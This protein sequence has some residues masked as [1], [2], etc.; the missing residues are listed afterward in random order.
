MRFV[1]HLLMMI[2]VALGIGF[3]LSHYALTDGK[4]FGAAQVGPWSAWPD[5][6]SAAP[7][8]Y[9]RG[10]LAREATL[11]L[12][13]SEGLRFTAAV[14]SEGLPLT[15]DCAYRMDGK[16]PLATFWTLVA[17]DSD[18]INIAAPDADPA[19]RSNA[20]ARANEGSLAINIGKRL[21]PGDWLEITG[22]GPFTLA[23]TLYD[24]AV[25]SGFSS[26]QSMPSIQRGKCA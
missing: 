26:D 1:F 12:G 22:T 16:T 20:I 15:R 18:G 19:M 11:Q 10:H 8:P 2:A 25:F 23:L 9:T 4:L 24:T 3:G 5:V 6:G 7:N 13:L 17:L 21:A 14:D